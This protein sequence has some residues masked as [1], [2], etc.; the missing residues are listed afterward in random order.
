MGRSAPDSSSGCSWVTRQPSANSTACRSVTDD[1]RVILVLAHMHDHGAAAVARAIAA[2]RGDDAVCALSPGELGA[3]TALDAH[4]RR[5]RRCRGRAG[6]RVRPAPRVRRRGMRAQPASRPSRRRRSRGR[7]P[8]E[9]D[10]AAAEVQALVVSWLA[11]LRRP[12]CTRPVGSGPSPPGRAASGSP[13]LSARA[14]PV[15]REVA[16]T[17]TRLSR[18]ERSRRWPRSDLAGRRRAAASQPVEARDLPTGDR[19]RSWWPVTGSTVRQT[20]ALA[21]RASQ[22]AADAG[23]GLLG[24][25]FETSPDGRTRRRRSVPALLDETSVA[26]AADLLERLCGAPA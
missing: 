17:S 5:E 22:L 20:R 19:G 10:Y 15:A 21:G 14:V 13:Q 9:R 11:G 23:C 6:A 24:L 12:W 3:A 18:S 16:A 1:G 25:T 7:M 26:A 4:D 8:R 2:R